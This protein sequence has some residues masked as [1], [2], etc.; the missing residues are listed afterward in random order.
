MTSIWRVAL[1]VGVSVCWIGACASSVEPSGATAPAAGLAPGGGTS[2]A[3]A[4]AVASPASPAVAAVATPVAN[5]AAVPGMTAA[6]PAMGVPA[7]TEPAA[8]V[9][10]TARGSCPAPNRR[11]SYKDPC[12]DIV[13]PCGINTGWDGDNYC[14]P[15]PS[16]E[17]GVQMHIGPTDYNDPAEVQK[18]IVEPGTEFLNNVAGENPLTEDKWTNHVQVRMR[19]GSHHWIIGL[20][21]GKIPGGFYTQE[22]CGGERVGGIGG[23]QSL[24][25]D[26]PPQGVPA[27][28]DE[29]FGN[30]MPGNSSVCINLHHYNLTDHPQLR[31]IWINVYFTDEASVT[32]RGEGIGMVGGTGLS[33][34]PGQSRTLTYSANF[35]A[36]GRIRSL[37]GHRHMWTERFAVWVNDDLIYD[38]W[39]WRESVT[40]MYDSITENPPINTDGMT[41]GAVSGPVN[42][43]AGDTLKFSCFVNNGSDTTLMFRNDVDTGEMCNLWGGTVGEGTGISGNYL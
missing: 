13:D 43:K 35:E 21:G 7:P 16:P 24:I 28:E 34:P 15:A 18:Y 9:K 23:G 39:D 5:P 33:L 25:L 11:V 31:E 17:E 6:Q 32:K 42:V 19:P 12:G 14:W 29:G 2:A 37:F 41:D 22:G 4:T 1:G 26:N 20:V 36:D 38:S 8:P 30:K 3:P 40:F 10:V 27:P